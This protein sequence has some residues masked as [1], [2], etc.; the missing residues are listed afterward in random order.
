MSYLDF[1]HSLFVSQFSTGIRFWLELSLLFLELIWF[2][3]DFWLQVLTSIWFLFDVCTIAVQSNC[4]VTVINSYLPLTVGIWSVSMQ[5]L[6]SL[7]IR[8]EERFRGDAR[9]NVR[10][11]YNIKMM[12]NIT[13]LINNIVLIFFR[14]LYHHCESLS[15]NVT[16]EI[17]PT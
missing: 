2:W 12:T 7:V 15:I 13:T 6:K 1:G 9:N 3:F 16:S 10:V 8:T 4:L 17:Q 11:K 14:F 5:W